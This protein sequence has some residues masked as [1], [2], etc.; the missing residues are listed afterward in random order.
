MNKNKIFAGIAILGLAAVSFFV[1]DTQ[2]D[3]ACTLTGAGAA[4]VA[5]GLTRHETTQTIMAAVGGAGGGVACKKFVE[6]LVEQPAQPVTVKVEAPNGSTTQDVTVTGYDLTANAS[7][8][9]NKTQR[10]FDCLNWQAYWLERLCWEGTIS[11]P[12]SS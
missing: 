7:P 11:P 3:V 8:P 1:W 10:F 2:R 6:S 12:E 4:A 5:A 9:A